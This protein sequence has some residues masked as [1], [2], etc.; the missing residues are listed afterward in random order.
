MPERENSKGKQKIK[1]TCPRVP[2]CATCFVDILFYLAHFDTENGS[3]FF[4][5]LK[6]LYSVAI[7]LITFTIFC[8]SYHN[9][10]IFRAHIYYCFY[11]SSKIKKI[12][13]IYIVTASIFL[14]KMLEIKVKWESVGEKLDNHKEEDTNVYIYC[15][16]AF[17]LYF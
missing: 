13:K 12:I 10:T 11:Y 8:C 1:L 2:V 15:I 9:L 7:Y 14:L 4:I 5:F 6:K 17:H 16:Y 3:S